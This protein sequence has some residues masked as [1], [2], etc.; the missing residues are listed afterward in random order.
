M[1]SISLEEW[2]AQH[3]WPQIHTMMLNDAFF[4]LMGHARQRTG[5]INGP[6]ASLI[7]SGYLTCQMFAIRRLCDNRWDVISL[8]RA[9]IEAE[10]RH[11]AALD[12][13]ERLGRRLD[14][15][16]HVCDLVNDYMQR[17]CSR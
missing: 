4:K 15:C 3:I 12:R 5:R 9:L 8:R 17:R 6:I 16:E 10:A 14:S 11:R 7:E 13:L 2:L 1:D